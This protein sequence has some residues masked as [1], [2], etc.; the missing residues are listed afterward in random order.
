MRK[1]T[2][3]APLKFKADSQTGEFTAI[4]SRFNVIDADGDVTVRGAFKD[5]QETLIESWNHNYGEPPVGRGIIYEQDHV[6]VVE[7]YFFLDTQGGMEHYKVVKNLGDLQE[8]SY[9][10]SVTESD[11]GEFE[12]QEVQFLRGLD[13]WGIAPVQKGSGVDTGT[14][15]IKT[16]E[17]AK[18]YPNEHSCRLEDPGKFVRCIRKAAKDE[19]DVGDYEATGKPYTLLICYTEDEKSEVQ[20]FRYDKDTWTAE[21]A[22][23][24]CRA[25]D[26]TFEAARDEGKR[27]EADGAKFQGSPRNP[28]GTHASRGYPGG[29][30][31][32]RNAWRIY[33]TQIQQGAIQ[34]TVRRI[35][36]IG[37]TMKCNL[38]ELSSEDIK[39]RSGACGRLDG[40]IYEKPSDY[41]LDSWKDPSDDDLTREDVQLTCQDLEDL[42]RACLAEIAKRH[43]CEEEGADS[44]SP[45]AKFTV[46]LGEC[47]AEDVQKAHDL[48]VQLGA[49][50]PSQGQTGRTGGPEGKPRSKETL[51]ARVALELV[52]AGV[53]PQE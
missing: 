40:K 52:E 37:A 29:R 33:L 49:Q 46:N 2:F 47:K 25:Y 44:A 12:G 43:A 35:G 50:C 36:M 32:W 31:G 3:T 17:G 20:A 42:K 41:G 13:V 11:K 24:H 5:G 48:L 15:T 14:V 30:A 9:T 18:P 6:A 27:L 45:K 22:G 10:F 51:A 8:W 7:G 4:F 23:A 39:P 53:D 16:L 26:G 19:N 28:Y 1:K 34:G 21:Q 38:P